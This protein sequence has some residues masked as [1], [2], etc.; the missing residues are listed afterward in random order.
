MKYNH[1]IVI[2]RFQPLH[3]GHLDLVRCAL[4]NCEQLT[5][6]IGSTGCAPNLKDPWTY[7][8]RKKMFLC[9]LPGENIKFVCV[10]DEPYD[11][12]AW[13]DS[14]FSATCPITGTVAIFGHKKDSTSF[15]LDMFPEW[16]LCE[17]A[18]SRSLSASE[19]RENLFDPSAPWHTEW[20]P[21][22]LQFLLYL[23]GEDRFSS[24]CKEAK[25]CRA[26]DEEWAS[27][28]GKK[29]G[30][31]HV[32]C[33]VLLHTTDMILL[34]ERG[35]EFG[36]G[37]LALPGGFV[38]AGERIKDACLRELEEETGVRLDSYSNFIFPI[39]PYDHPG[40]SLRGR[41]FTNV[42]T[43]GVPA[44]PNL[45]AGDDASSARM[46]PIADLPKLKPRFFSD[47]FH[48]VNI[49]LRKKGLL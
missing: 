43:V 37:T 5:I 4:A 34:I 30:I 33:D 47:H 10:E 46:Y 38:N 21:S 15:Y 27:E 22:S 39:T 32:A 8:E 26:H 48:I 40:R 7:E 44:V 13:V 28:G 31:Q 2:G 42:M 41:I 18:P 6:V 3:N 16:T 12:A 25:A 19:I 14:V 36:N 20:T 35:G 29:Y 11:D 24:L 1:G 49:E 45:K 23:L 17:V 9:A